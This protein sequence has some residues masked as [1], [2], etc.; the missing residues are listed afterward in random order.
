MYK[1]TEVKMP[2]WYVPLGI[3]SSF[4]KC[5]ILFVK[6][7]SGVSRVPSLPHFPRDITV[8]DTNPSFLVFGL[9]RVGSL[10]SHIYS[11]SSSLHLFL[12]L[13]FSHRLAWV[14]IN[15]DWDFQVPVSC[16][17]SLELWTQSRLEHGARRGMGLTRAKS[18][19]IL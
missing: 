16:P 13:L 17:M 11:C 19:W 1:N 9:Y 4:I 10:S 8:S 12:P 14:T 2:C 5:G 7:F 3:I 18:Y 15:P 6:N